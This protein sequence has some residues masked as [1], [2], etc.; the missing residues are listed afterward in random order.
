[1]NIKKA[2]R[3]VIVKILFFVITVLVMGVLA[4]RFAPWI[5]E[6]VK[7]P[8]ALREFVRSFNG[9]G[10]IVFVLLQALIVLTVFIPVDIVLN[11][12]GGYVYGTPMG[13]L[14]SMI[15]LLLGAVC[16]FYISR[17]LGFD[18]IN[19]FVSKKRIDKI[20]SI[21]NSKRGFFSLLVI[22]LIPG[23]PKDLMMYIAGLTPVI[24]W[25][26]FYVYALSRIPA[27]LIEVSAGA[28]IQE[29]DIKGIII[30]LTG[31]VLFIAVI[32]VLRKKYKI[33]KSIING[34]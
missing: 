33:S 12:L 30:T 4:V 1:M 21:L 2:D 29:R 27:T 23:I 28:Q 6:E 19:K 15:G 14:L 32:I 34:D 22:Y 26:M 5:I 13:F 9:F 16:S 18:L 7:Y 20:S 10:F 17:I 3:K 8:G 11:V 25:K 24:A 31:L